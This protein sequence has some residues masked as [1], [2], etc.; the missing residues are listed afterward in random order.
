MPIPYL[1]NRHWWE[2]SRDERMY[3]AVLWEK[4]RK[5]PA[6]FAKWLKKTAELPI[7]SAGDWELGYDVA[8]S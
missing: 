2:L 4:G 3:C 6:S 1:N 7:K 8:S 5:H